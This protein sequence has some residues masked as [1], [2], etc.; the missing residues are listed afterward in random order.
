MQRRIKVINIYSDLNEHLDFI[1]EIENEFEI[2]RAEQIIEEAY[3]D[4]W[5]LEAN[6]ELQFVMMGD[7][8]RGKLTINGIKHS[9]YTKED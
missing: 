2:D 7:Y 4:W 3:N 5:D 8:I 1:V 9:W 6:P